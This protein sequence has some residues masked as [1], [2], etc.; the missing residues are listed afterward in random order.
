MN[1]GTKKLN[2]GCGN[3]V[4]EGWVNLD[5]ARLPGVDVVHDIEKLPLPFSDGEFNEIFCQDILE[6]VSYVPVLRDLYRTLKKGG[7]ILIRV[8]HFTSKNF[9]LD[10]TH[11]HAFSI[12]TF[13]FF[14][15]G[16]EFWNDRP[17]YFDF[18]FEKKL[19]CQITFELSSRLFFYNRSVARLVNSSP[20]MQKFYE[21]SFLS[22]IFPAENIVIVLEK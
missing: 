12:N 16:T 10:P 7:R 9:Y 18:S 22:R 4:K 6:H 15:R 2:L 8:P 21:S 19:G 3:D 5:S 1:N 20:R 11:R 13:D 17:Y 14:V